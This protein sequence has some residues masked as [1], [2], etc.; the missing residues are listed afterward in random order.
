MSQARFIVN[1]QEGKDVEETAKRTIAESIRLVDQLNAARIPIVVGPN[2]SLP[3]G[4]SV[5][6]PVF[7]WRSGSLTISVW[8]GKNLV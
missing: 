5:G 1:L 3:E 4:M 7:D 2:E 6:Q 8:N